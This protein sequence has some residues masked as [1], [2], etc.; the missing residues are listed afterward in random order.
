MFRELLVSEWAPFGA[1]RKIRSRKLERHYEFLI[2]WNKVLN[3]T[4]I[5]TLDDVVRFHY[6][7]SLF[8]GSLLP[9]GPQRVVDIGSGAGFPGIPDR[10]TAA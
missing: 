3:L 6:C 2:R 1:C 4:R 5:R 7:E 9:E 8:L 10:R